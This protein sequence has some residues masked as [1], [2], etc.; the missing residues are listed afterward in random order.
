MRVRNF[1][2]GIPVHFPEVLDQKK[3][4]I[5]LTS[6]EGRSRIVCEDDSAKAA[7]VSTHAQRRHRGDAPGDVETEEVLRRSVSERVQGETGS[8]QTGGQGQADRALSCPLR[9]PR[10]L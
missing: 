10:P 6:I 7:G 4:Q 5:V 2:L 9:V 1:L 8:P 3:L